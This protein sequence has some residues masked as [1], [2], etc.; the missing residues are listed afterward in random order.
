MQ[1]LVSQHAFTVVM[2]A[3][4]LTVLASLIGCYLFDLWRAWRAR[5]RRVIGSRVKAPGWRA[6]RLTNGQWIV[7]RDR[8]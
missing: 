4:I 3:Y 2:V 1:P 5:R 6:R 7:Q 8:K